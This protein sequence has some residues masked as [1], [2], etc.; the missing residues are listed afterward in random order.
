M[1]SDFKLMGSQSM[2][3]WKSSL[4]HPLITDRIL[5]Y[6]A[7]EAVTRVIFPVNSRFVISPHHQNSGIGSSGGW[8]GSAS[9]R[10]TLDR[11]ANELFSGPDEEGY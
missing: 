7:A 2:G 4:D 3:V 5:Q 1:S 6:S 8:K 9:A 11:A 10:S